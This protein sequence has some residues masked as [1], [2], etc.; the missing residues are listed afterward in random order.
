MKKL[1][2]YWKLLK[3]QGLIIKNKLFVS[4]NKQKFKK[5]IAIIS[6][7]KWAGK[8]SEDILLKHEL[9]K[10]NVD[11]DIVSWEDPNINYEKYNIV[12]IRS[13]WGYQNNINAFVKWLDLL[14]KQDVVVINDL[15]IIKNT[16]SKK[17]QFNILDKYKISHIETK[18]ITKKQIKT[19]LL[20]WFDQNCLN[21]LYVFKP[22][23][24]ASG[25][26]TLI[27]DAK[28]KNSLDK[29]YQSVLAE[30]NNGIMV[31][32]YINGI[33][34]GEISLIF[35]DK[36][37]SHA[38]RRHSGVFDG[39]IRI[40]EIPYNLIDQKLLNIAQNIVNLTEFQ[41]ITFCRLDFVK[42][43]DDYLIMEI[44]CIDPQLFLT[45]IKEKKRRA[46]ALNLLAKKI[47]ENA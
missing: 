34:E 14:K 22:M 27:V 8:V 31:Q 32:P 6:C 44:E 13:I 2:W 20:D 26:N 18:F 30:E 5:N 28:N 36:K 4:L 35:I 43:E 10:L 21:E 15:D 7:N 24:S 46:K 39:F 19:S 16:L 38:I 11:V 47:I 41:N 12:V 3:L 42:N 37:F 33:E 9:N 29:I 40:G 17:D 45:S 25:S 23:I 1:I